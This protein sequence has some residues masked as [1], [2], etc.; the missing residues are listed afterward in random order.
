MLKGVRACAASLLTDCQ[1]QTASFRQ[2]WTTYESPYY[3]VQYLV[4]VLKC[5]NSFIVTGNA[6]VWTCCNLYCIFKAH[7][8]KYLTAGWSTS[9]QIMILA[10]LF[11]SVETSKPALGLTQSHTKSLPG[12][13]S[14]RVQ[15]PKCEADHIPPSSFKTKNSWNVTA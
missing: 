13:L 14:Y 2:S 15:V 11:S 8:A 3:K 10:G 7:S 9:F 1:R 12:S 5:K 4:A 6:V